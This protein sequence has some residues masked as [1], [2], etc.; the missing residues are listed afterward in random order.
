[1]ASIWPDGRS[2]KY[3]IKFSFG[4]RDYC[5]SC[6]TKTKRDAENT[7]ATVEE[8]L[9]LLNTGRLSVPA[10]A[11]PGTW[12]L[13]GGRLSSKPKIS[14]SSLITVA[15]VCE[16]YFKDQLDKAATTLVGE[17]T[18]INHL[19]RGLGT[20]TRFGLIKTEDIQNYV[21]QRQ[22]ASNRFGG[23][24]S[25]KTIKKE[26]TTFMQIW[27]WARQRG[28]VN[29]ICPVKDPDRPRKWGVKIPKPEETERFMTW[30]EIDRRIAR[31]GLSEAEKKQLWRYL[32]LDEKQVVELLEFVKENAQ[33]DF[34]YP[35]FAFV[36]Y[37]GARR[38]EMCRSIIDDIKLS[39][40]MVILRERKRRKDLAATTRDVPMRPALKE[41]MDECF[42][43]HPGGQHTITPPLSMPRREVKSQLSGLS[44]R[45]ADHHFDQTLKGSKWQVLRGFHVLR[46]SFGAICTRAGIPMNVI[47]KWMGHT[48]DEMMRLYQH[49]FPQDEKRWMEK[50]PF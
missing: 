27:D 10:D 23:T 21:N 40:G 5:R 45:E 3:V 9:R 29:R 4:G 50:L 34:I 22:K 32:F 31:G 47:A 46:H 37:T 11:D 15:E 8:T 39:E 25:G 2:G 19:K 24:V 28:C 33:Y 41:V 48:T 36:A 12:I 49:L 16:A 6:R 35:M 42:K 18:H 14:P 1:M 13:S 38:S 30:E 43:C 17:S 20:S 26:L 7:K 44:P